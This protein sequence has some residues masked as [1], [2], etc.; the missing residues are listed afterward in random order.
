[1][2]ETSANLCEEQSCEVCSQIPDDLLVNTGR[3]DTFPPEV[4]RL[5]VL[6]LDNSNDLYECPGCKALFEWEDLP[7]YYGSGN[8]AEER[9]TRLNPE[10]E[11]MARALLDPAP[12]A[13]NGSEFLNR[14][15]AT[16]SYDLVTTL[17]RYAANRHKQAFSA[18]IGPLVAQ[19]IAEGNGTIFS[20]ISTYC[21]SDRGRLTEVLQLLDAGG[22]EI[23]RS[24]EYLR[25][26]CLEQLERAY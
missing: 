8:N 13:G 24:A 19:L 23:G 15:F 6:N 9:L 3:D 10:Q 5:T 7:Q 14:A 1:M 26:T 22:P 21:G 12:E 18:F 2:A 11:L 4:R 25:K 20:I 17:L 16:L